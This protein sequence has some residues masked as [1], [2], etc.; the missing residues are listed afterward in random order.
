MEIWNL[1]HHYTVKCRGY[2]FEIET[3]HGAGIQIVQLPV[4]L[5]QTVQ[6]CFSIGIKKLHL[7]D[8]QCQTLRYHGKP[9]IAFISTV[10]PSSIF[11]LGLDQEQ[12]FEVYPSLHNRFYG[13]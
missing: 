6:H 10:Y 13:N 4:T 7:S 5:I 11:I 12:I 9:F 2:A 3:N 1:I 8:I